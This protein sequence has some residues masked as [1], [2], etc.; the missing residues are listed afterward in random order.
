M[1][2]CIQTDFKKYA[3]KVGDKKS[4]V[5]TKNESIDKLVARIG[6]SPFFVFKALEIHFTAQKF[7]IFN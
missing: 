6:K 3:V 5:S 7:Q 2:L 1:L 4:I